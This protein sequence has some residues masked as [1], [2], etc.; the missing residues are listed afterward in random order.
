MLNDTGNSA[1]SSPEDEFHLTADT[2]GQKSLAAKVWPALLA[3]V[4]TVG[5]IGGY[6]YLRARNERALAAQRAEAEKAKEVAPPVAQV[7]QDEVRLAGGQA[8]VGGTV[9]NVSGEKLEG[10]SVE[11]EL[12]SR[13]GG[14]TEARQVSVEPRDLQPGEE[15]KFSLQ[16][17]PKSWSGVRVA[18]LLS[19]ARGGELPFKPE[20][21]AKRPAEP[22]P[23]PKVVVEPRPRRK[24]DDYINTPDTPI[25]IP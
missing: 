12:K 22:R 11:I 20:L 19:A 6:F 17:V 3:L 10:L 1:D 18:K 15:G 7:F 14:G 21:G 8:M 2:V 9:R 24:G 5:L 25:R 13:A 4:I 23:A 16:I